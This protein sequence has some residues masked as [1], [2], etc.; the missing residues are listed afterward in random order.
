MSLMGDV[1]CTTTPQVRRVNF[2]MDKPFTVTAAYAE[3]AELPSGCSSDI[4]T[5]KVPLFAYLEVLVRRCMLRVLVIHAAHGKIDASM[6]LM[7][8]S[9]A[10]ILSTNTLSRADRLCCR[11]YFTCYRSIRWRLYIGQPVS[12]VDA[13]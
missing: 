4:G 8:V 1:N 9:R 2:T 7:C 10:R 6:I 12:T 5:F 3:G 13:I 11:A